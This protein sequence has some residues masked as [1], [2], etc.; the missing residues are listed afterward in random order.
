MKSLSMTIQ[1][2]GDNLHFPVV[3]PVFICLQVKKFFK[4]LEF[5]T[6]TLFEAK[7]SRV[8]L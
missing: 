6:L 2:K 8:T 1:M 4:S 3:F 7:G 5:R